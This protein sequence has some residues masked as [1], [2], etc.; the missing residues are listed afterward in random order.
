M[1]LSDLHIRR[2]DD[3]TYAAIWGPFLLKS[4]FQPIFKM[5]NGPT[6]IGAFEALC[7]PIRDG[8]ATT[9]DKFFPLVPQNERYRVE[10][11]TRAVHV[12]NAPAVLT[13]NEGL[14]LNFDPSIF[15]DKASIDIALD[16]L[17]ET[18]SIADMDRKRVVCEVTEHKTNENNLRQLVS[19]L[20]GHGYRIAVDDYGSN[21]SDMVRVRNL[22][23][24]IVKFDAQ[25]ISH[26]MDSGQA[27]AALL[28][29]M[30]ATFNERGIT[31]L[32]EGIEFGW[33]LD[34]A[35][36]CGVELVQ[37][38]VLARPQTVPSDFHDFRSKQNMN[39]PHRRASLALEEPL[40]KR[41]SGFHAWENEITSGMDVPVLVP[42]KMET[43]REMMRDVPQEVTRDIPRDTPRNVPVA[44]MSS[45]KPRPDFGLPAVESY[46]PPADIKQGSFTPAFG[47]RGGSFGQKR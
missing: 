40:I 34:L 27:G 35:V 4:G 45:I 38:F 15:V 41:L 22:S 33:Q 16:V 25:W 17:D 21:A 6:R 5:G 43:V 42:N 19:Q 2:H 37:G 47:T 46:V 18:L 32:F 10:L 14:Y 24:D 23:P 8:N 1:K 11:Q 31:T 29:D 30:V 39:G 36:E 44:S 26:M 20:R 3:G 9:P 28:K 13:D 7:R 12:L